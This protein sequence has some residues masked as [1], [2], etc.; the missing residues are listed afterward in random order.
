MSIRQVRP[1]VRQLDALRL[2]HGE[3]PLDDVQ[4]ESLKRDVTAAMEVYQIHKA[5]RAIEEFVVDDLSRWYV[6]LVRDRLW[7]EGEDKDKTV[8]SRGPS[9]GALDIRH[10]PG[11]ARRAVR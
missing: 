2:A 7:K 10:A 4:D 1:R 9:R 3:G 5:V 8:A 6:K 11:L